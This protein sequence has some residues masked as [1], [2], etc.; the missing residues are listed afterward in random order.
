[1]IQ[2]SNSPSTTAIAKR[3]FAVEQRASWGGGE[4]ELAPY[5]EPIRCAEMAAPDLSSAELQYR[6]GPI[7]READ[8]NAATYP[9]ARLRDHYVRIR[10]LI[11]GGGPTT[12][13]TGVVAEE[14][15]ELMGATTAR[16]IQLFRCFGLGYLLDRQPVH[17][18]FSVFDDAGAV[19][20]VRR[21]PGFNKRSSRGAAP[22]GNRSGST[23]AAGAHAFQI[24]DA[25]GA[26][27]NNLQALEYLLEFHIPT[28]GP[29]WALAGQYAE[30]ATIERVHDQAGLTVW[31]WLNALIEPRQGFAFVVEPL[32]DVVYLRVQSVADVEVPFGDRTLAEN[33]L[34][35]QFTM[36]SEWPYP[37]L[38]AD[39]PVLRHNSTGRFDGFEAQGEF[40][41]VAMS[42]DFDTGSLEKAWSDTLWDA[43]RTASDDDDVSEAEGTPAENDAYRARD[44]FDGVGSR[45]RFPKDFANGPGPHSRDGYPC[46]TCDDDG[47]I[48]AD[49]QSGWF[50]Q[51]KRLL[52]TLPLLSHIDYTLVEE[53]SV[54]EDGYGQPVVGDLLEGA[55]PEYLPLLVMVF[56]S[57]PTIEQSL[58]GDI[59][60]H[61]PNGRWRFVDQLGAEDPDLA[62]V[63]V[64]PLANEIGVELRAPYRHYF[65]QGDWA[66]AEVAPTQR[67]PEFSWTQLLCTGFFETDERFRVRADNPEGRGETGRTKI[68]SVPGAECW[69]I[70]Q[71]TILDIAPDGNLY[72]YALGLDPKIRYDL[73][74]LEA[75]VAGAIAWH[76]PERQ[77]VELTI[78]QSGL[79]VPLLTVLDAINTVKGQESVRTIISGRVIDCGSPA[80]ATEP[81]TPPTTTIVSGWGNADFEL[82]PNS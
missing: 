42:W 69:W 79:F 33:P 8:V 18:C 53:G 24:G 55:E 46:P 50:G 23:T 61:T 76:G 57:L 29:T 6:Y 2:A 47:S 10:Q 21:F 5:V 30:L 15:D 63:G 62:S 51:D 65:A 52:P 41:K 71:D 59:P 56:D 27:W 40:V 44:R 22:I 80:T 77:A 70:V 37:H 1:M 81:G 7:R 35:T 26:I 64:R 74:L 39:P 32:G 19:A 73:G 43:Y 28:G 25:G 82:D 4:W 13:W 38:I 45:F 12:L 11:E 36:P 48:D 3:Y 31:Q 78:R 60:H 75:A 54:D 66:A 68:I 58:A 16:G 67:R 9:P 49:T 14:A 17:T 20:E 72:W 34:R